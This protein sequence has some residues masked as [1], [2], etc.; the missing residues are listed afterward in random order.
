MSKNKERRSHSFFEKSLKRKKVDSAII[1]N[2]IE[3]DK[4]NGWTLILGYIGVFFILAGI[5]CLLPLFTIFAFPNELKSFWVFFIP[6]IVSVAIGIPLTFLLKNKKAGVLGK[7]M[8]FVLIILVYLLTIFVNSI[9][10]YI[11][12][13]LGGLGLSFTSGFFEATSCITT[14]GFTSLMRPENVAAGLSPSAL[15]ATDGHIFL[16]H[17][18]ILSFFGGVGLILI[19]SS[20]M[21]NKFGVQMFYSEGHSDRLLPTLM[22]TAQV[23][24][25]IC[26]GLV[27]INSVLYYVTGMNEWSGV[28]TDYIRNSDGS[29]V[30]KNGVQL[31]EATPSYFDALCFAMSTI[32]TC[33]VGVRDASIAFYNNVGVESVSVI[34]MMLSSINFLLLFS[35]L[36]GRVKKVWHD[37][38]VKYFVYSTL[39]FVPLIILCFTLDSGAGNNANPSQQFSFLDELRHSIF[40][41]A[42][43][44]STT[45]FE[46]IGA[47]G[48][49][50]TCSLLT[51]CIF[52]IL[53]AVGGSAG[54]TAGGI[55]R[56][57][58]V[59]IIKSIGWGIRDLLFN[60]TGN[61]IYPRTV[62]KAGQKKEIS[63][64]EYNDCITYTVLFILIIVIAS[65]ILIF[66][67]PSKFN[68][69]E[70]LSEATSALSSAG[71]STGIAAE[72]PEGI[73]WLLS[74]LMFVGRVEIYTII[75]GTY[76]ITQ[77]IFTKKERKSVA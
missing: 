14:S 68:Y 56:Y 20:T 5:V 34:F 33:G 7:Y 65:L 67:I 50:T 49:A 76:K 27:V 26:V 16:M 29:I 19:L 61:Y 63:G 23:I 8:D 24:L 22:R 4:V 52:I 64:K 45:G 60:K 15:L 42:S 41:Y 32:S 53:M 35:L 17:R 77:D 28:I 57:R 11:S 74:L 9:P 44:S 62:E 1:T 30:V 2:K 40:Y 55:K 37:S 54:S 58:V 31:I 70:A 18:S 10:Y 66:V 51:L 73:L 43:L 48:L 59:V 13:D 75:F 38:E 69:I 39:I 6:G 3:K 21:L 46:S 72:G 12:G 36:V 25:G 71:L 47:G